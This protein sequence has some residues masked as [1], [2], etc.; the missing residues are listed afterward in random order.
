[1]FIDANVFIYAYTDKL[2]RGKKSKAF[3]DK[4]ARGEQNATTSALVVNEVLYYMHE[5]RGMGGVEDAHRHIRS[6]NSLSMLPLDDKVVAVS[7][8]YMRNGLQVT[9][10]FHAATMKLAGIDT[11]CSYDRGF[12]EKKGIIRKEP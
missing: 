5:A 9:D 6:M 3:L 8:E 7:L 10:A 4:V 12:D 11:I 1:M 2:E